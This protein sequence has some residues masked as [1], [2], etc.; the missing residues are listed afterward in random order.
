MNIKDKKHLK[1]TFKNKVNQT[2]KTMITWFILC[3][4]SRIGTYR[5]R[6]QINDCPWLE[7]EGT[8]EGTTWCL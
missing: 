2:H 4:Q 1:K 8:G 7:E 6:K 5:D 3:D